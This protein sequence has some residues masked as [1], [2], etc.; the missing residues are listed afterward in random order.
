[1]TIRDIPWTHPLKV[2][3]SSGLDR[4][5]SG[6]YEALD[7]LENEWPLKQGPRYDRA[8]ASC[9]RALARMTPPA[10]A[11]EAFVAACFEAG[12]SAVMAAPLPYGQSSGG[13]AEAAV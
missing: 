6:V 10:V 9:Q 11:R 2:T 12:M 7:F 4:T 3:L 5:F 1:M 8:V 13:G